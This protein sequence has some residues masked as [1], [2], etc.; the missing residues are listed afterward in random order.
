MNSQPSSASSNNFSLSL[1]P[2][3]SRKNVKAE[4]GDRV[5]VPL[6][7]PVYERDGLRNYKEDPNLNKV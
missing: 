7:E 3:R 1:K 4:S 6:V 5:S 2:S